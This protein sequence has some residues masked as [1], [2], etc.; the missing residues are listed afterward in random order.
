MPTKQ[1][2]RRHGTPKTELKGEAYVFG[3]GK[4][5]LVGKLF[6]ETS[7]CFSCLTITT[8][9][10]PMGFVEVFVYAIFAAAG[11]RGSRS[12]RPDIILL[13]LSDQKM[14]SMSQR[15]VRLAIGTFVGRNETEISKQKLHRAQIITHLD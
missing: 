11:M 4:P 10:G 14:H 1:E 5:V 8:F 2:Y 9:L 3:E 7:E 15:S 13:T 12:K 6:K